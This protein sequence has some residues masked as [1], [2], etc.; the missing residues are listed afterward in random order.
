MD[1]RTPPP[2][3][4]I[5]MPVYNGERYLEHTLNTVL[6][7]TFTDFCIF[8][9]DNAS[10]DRTEEICRA[11]AQRDPRITYI[12]NP[13]NLGAAGNYERCFQPTQS[14]YFRWQNVDDPIEPTLI[15]RCVAALDKQTDAVLAYGRTNIIDEHGNVTER[16]DDK[17]SLIQDK[18]S[19]RFIACL[20]NIGLQNLMYGLIRRDALAHTARLKGYLAADINLIGELALY[21]KFIEIPE[22]LFSRRM[23]PDCSSW[24]RKDAERQ[25]NFW[26]PSKR[27][28]VMQTWRSVFEY[29][30]ATLKAPIS[31][32]EKISVCHFLLRHTYWRRT[33]MW[34]ELNDLVR[35]GILR[36]F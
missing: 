32:Q 17:L 8:I 29:Y 9:S 27:K 4:S 7:Q 22:Q 18:P 31:W 6:D 3:V 28:L 33:R 19:D 20:L 12:R 36:K 2:R 26:D 25:K 35:Y 24:D 1:A 16:Y 5:G 11:Y 14:E 15:E 34:T 23:H 10:T 21:G 13:V 30:K